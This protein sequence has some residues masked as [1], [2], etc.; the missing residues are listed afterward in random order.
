MTMP[1]KILLLLLIMIICFTSG[2]FFH[3]QPIKTVFIPGSD[4]LKV[5]T[6]TL[7][8]QNDV[9]KFRSKPIIIYDTL[10]FRDT[11]F[12]SKAFTANLDTIIK[13][14][15][16]NLKYYFPN[17]FFDFSFRRKPDSVFIKTVTIQ[18]PIEKNESWVI[19]PAIS[20]GSL[21]LGFLLGKL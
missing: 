19:H 12:M 4:T 3:K 18:I 20:A 6:D 5:L 8:V 2:Y 9:I 7:L 21:I 13:S 10:N 16:L 14:D 17:N 11:V 1:S 15:T